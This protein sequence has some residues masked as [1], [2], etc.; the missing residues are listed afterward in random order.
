MPA[1]GEPC[2]RC[3]PSGFIAWSR[4]RTVFLSLS[5]LLL[6]PLFT[7]TGVIVRLFHEKQASIAASWERAGNTNLQTG[8]PEVAIENF[9]NSLLYAPEDS[10]VQLELA[11]ALA[12]QGQ[13]DEAENYLFTLRTADPENSMIDLQL[14]RI[15]AGRGDIAAAVTFYHDAAFGQW[16]SNSHTNRLATRRE[17]IEFLLSHNLRDQARAE[18]LS[19]AADN[20]VDP[21]VLD[22][23]AGYLA[24]AVDHQSALAEYQAVLR[25]AP[26]NVDALMGAGNAALAL[27]QFPEADRYFTRALQHGAKRENVASLRDLAAAAA[28]L[29]PFNN[30]VTE[31]ERQVRTVEIFQAAEQHAKAC[32]PALVTGSDTLPNNLKPLAAER[33]ALPTNLTRSDFSA[34]PEYADQALDWAFAVEQAIPAQCGGTLADRAIQYLAGRNKEGHA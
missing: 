22:A 31:R 27:Y 12:A 3:F 6:I 26:A 1:G 2:P 4:S 29:D 7:T 11:E 21:D 25:I 8:N 9:R 17:L 20:P 19:L 24:N 32:F 30:R 14:A 5:A 18:A 28:E 16:P 13:T 34:H 15:S 33:A 10:G 23:A